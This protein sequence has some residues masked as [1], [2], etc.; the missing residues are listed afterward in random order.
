MVRMSILQ[1]KEYSENRPL[2]ERRDRIRRQRIVKKGLRQLGNLAYNQFP[3][4]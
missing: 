2:V 3:L 4:Q 1:P